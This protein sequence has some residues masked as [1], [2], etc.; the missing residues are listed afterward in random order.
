MISRNKI[1]GVALLVVAAA[2]CVFFAAPAK[3][4]AAAVTTGSYQAVFL[5]NGLVVYGKL[6]GLGQPYPVL[7]DVYYIRRDVNNE[8]KEV[9]SQLVKRGAEFHGPDRMVLNAQHVM[10]V[11]PVRD[12]STISKMIQDLNKK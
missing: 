3:S 1:L 7:T 2:A 5:Q 12:G 10:F 6:E 11:E 4:T 9:R 8:T